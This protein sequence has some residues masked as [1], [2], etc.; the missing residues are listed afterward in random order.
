MKFPEIKFEQHKLSNGLK[1]FLNR[2]TKIPMVS[3][4]TMFHVGSKDEEDGKSGLAHLFEH[5]MF[6]GSPNIKSGQFDLLLHKRGGNSNAYTSW[7]VT[8]YHM[9]VPSNEIEFA[10]WLDSDRY[11]GFNVSEESLDIQKDVV[12]EEKMTYVDNAPYGSVEDEVSKRLFFNSGYKRPV[13]G[14]MNDVKN[15]SLSDL[16]IFFNNYYRADNSVVSVSGDIDIDNTLKLLEKYYSGF[17]TG[18]MVVKSGYNELELNSEIIDTIYDKITNPGLFI[19]YRIPKVGDKD[20]YVFKIISNILGDGESSELYKDLVYESQMCNEITTSV[21]GAEEVS[22]LS[23]NAIC[24]EGI[25]PDSVLKR[26]DEKLEH[27]FNFGLTENIYSKVLNKIETQF[28]KS[29]NLINSVADRLCYYENI[30]K[31]PDMINS[32]INNYFNL[33]KETLISVAKKYL[34]KNKRVVLYYLPEN[35]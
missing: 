21:Y 25:S 1:I 19:T 7:D 26:I 22:I 18:N 8:S 28:Y 33:D 34:Q 10:F 30:L 5:L 24:N 4:H 3:L 35:K 29:R 16:E 31:K 2:N 14:D 32:E 15:L 17:N 12:H 23:I 13:I 9:T 27:I 11:T 6:E 20:Y